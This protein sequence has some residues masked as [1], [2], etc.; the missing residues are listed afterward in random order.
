MAFD[1][2][3]FF[4]FVQLGL[5]RA[6]G[7]HYRQ[8][9]KRFAMFA[10]AC[11]LYPLF[12]A[13]IWSGYLLDDIL[14]PGYRRQ[15]IKQPVFIVGNP[16]SGTTFLYNVLAQ[17]THNFTCTRTW[18]TILAPSVAMRKLCRALATLDRRLGSP[19]LRQVALLEERLQQEVS[20]HKFALQTPEEDEHFLLHTCSALELWLFTAL[21][22]GAIP[23][24]WFDSI[25]SDQDR[26]RI[27]GYYE[28]CIQRHLY[29]HRDDPRAG[30]RYLSKNPFS[31]AKIGSLYKRFPD[32]KF[33]YL[34]RNPLDMIPSW[35]NSVAYGWRIPGGTP[36]PYGS[37]DFV[38]DL[39]EHWYRYPLN[40]FERAP[41]DSYIVVRF[42]DMV[43]DI[44]GTVRG[45]YERFGLE[46]S[47]SLTL[48]VQKAAER[49]RRYRS[50]HT[51]SLEQVGLPRERIVNRLRDV[52]V[53]FGFDTREPVSAA[54]V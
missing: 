21:L 1:F 17:D 38:L 11:S 8:T 47:G 44:E 34:A 18:E 9:P 54:E 27:M 24:T 35:I 19:L 42:D 45:I 15:P 30:P 40:C 16:R 49:S 53:R 50:R 52:F 10:G 4:R 6:K 51:Y 26:E 12:E 20:M 13:A 7:K 48:A 33:V 43:A 29:A 37:R 32:A 3:S 36:D 2:Y 5:F 28:R 31:T 41:R 14:Y 23:L 46:S 39:A 25:P 22:E